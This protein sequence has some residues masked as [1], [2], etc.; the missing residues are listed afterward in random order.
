[1]VDPVCFMLFLPHLCYNFMYRKPVT[2]MHHILHYFTARE[3]YISHT[4]HRH[5]F[6]PINVLWVEDLTYIGEDEQESGAEDDTRADRQHGENWNEQQECGT[7]DDPASATA[8]RTNRSRSRSIDGS[9]QLP[10]A[11]PVTPRAGSTF[12]RLNSRRASRSSHAAEAE[13]ESEKTMLGPELMLNAVISPLIRP[14]RS[15]SKTQHS[16][17]SRHTVPPACGQIP[18]PSRCYVF[19]SEDDDIIYTPPIMEY[20]R[21]TS[22]ALAELEIQT[23]WREQCLSARSRS[24]IDKAQMSRDLAASIVQCKMWP[25]YRHAQFLLSARAQTEVMSALEAVS[26]NET[27]YS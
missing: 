17:T 15:V 19:L 8:S 23:Q 9:A 7:D 3:L 11:T 27:N 4:L 16:R 22:T 13:T 5:F 21:S 25:R 26:W 6:W 10:P 18:T 12:R 24:K 14:P 1:L 20:L 2:P